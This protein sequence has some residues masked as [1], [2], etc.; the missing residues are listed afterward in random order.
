MQQLI[1][2]PAKIFRHFGVQALL[3]KQAKLSPL[4]YIHAGG[5]CTP[6]L[7]NSR[8][9]IFSIVLGLSCAWASTVQAGS[10][11][12]T[13]DASREAYS[14]INPDASP[15]QLAEAFRGRGVFRQS[16]VIA[17]AKDIETAGLGPLYNQLSCL[18]CHPKNGRGQPPATPQ[19]A[20]RS[21]LIRLSLPGQDPHGGPLPHPV[22]GGQLNE[23]GIP[24]VPGEGM[25]SV[26]YREHKVTLADGETVALRTPSYRFAELQYG[27]LPDG[28]QFSPRVGPPVFGLGLLEAVDGQTI[29][30]LA[31]KGKQQGVHGHPN[32]V[33]DDERQRNAIGRFGLK[34]NVATLKQQIA[35]AFIGDMGI[36]SSLHPEENCTGI[37][38]ACKQTPSARQPELD[39][40]QLK[41]VLLY[42]RLLQVPARRN[43]GDPAVRQGERLFDALGCTACHT[44]ALTTGEF[45]ELPPLAKQTIHPYTDLL[46]HDMGEGLEDRRPDFQAGGREWR[47]PPLWGIGLIERINEHSYFLHDGRA[48]NLTEAV[49]WHGGEA[50]PSKQRFAGLSADERLA[51][52]RFLES[53]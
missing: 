17:P 2:N 1:S 29:L 23:Q 3:A 47:T 35:G 33:W 39:D 51:V 14:R 22:Y 26:D 38:T 7:N 46:V 20:M 53:L 18:S 40:A 10:G 13:A 8:K 48:R 30:Q 37:Q 41:S 52:I 31:E 9:L 49:L 15:E 25:V 45:P 43:T 32:I 5:A 16:W 28:I 34:A 21:M 6:A 27:P 19:Q 24:G 50:L 11:F 4:A 36:T 42:L 12:E 44:P